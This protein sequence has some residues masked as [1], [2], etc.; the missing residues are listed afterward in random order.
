MGADH[1]D[2][3][4]QRVERG[5]PL[6]LALP[7]D[8]VEPA[9]RQHH[10]GI[11]GDGGEE[12]EILGGER[13]ALAVRHRQRAHGD[14]LGP[15][16]RHRRGAHRDPR[17]ELHRAFGRALGDLDPL[18]ADGESNQARV[19]LFRPLPLECLQRS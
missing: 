4:G 15:E 16:R 1:G 6:L 19:A 8:L 7:H 12:P 10:R 17:D 13:A 9:V 11:S 18:P 3:L 14:A 2:A 5:L